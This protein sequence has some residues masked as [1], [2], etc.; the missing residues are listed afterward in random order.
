M[1][2]NCITPI[3]LSLLITF[4][5]P[6]S[7]SICQTKEK[8]KNLSI[9]EI[10]KLRDIE[11]QPEKVMDVI[12]LRQGMKIGEAGASYGYFTFKLSARVGN[13]GIVYANDIA[14]SALDK[15]ERKCKSD[16]ITNIKTV[17]GIED[18]PLFPNKNLDMIVVF[19]CLFEFSKPME[20]MLNSKKYLNSGGKLV[21]VDP[22]PS[23]EKNG[24][25]LTRKQI[26][27]YAEKAGYAVIM[28]D[29]SFL[30]RMMIIMLE[31]KILK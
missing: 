14:P 13:T 5:I 19:D 29:D 28:V 3:F 15:I 10:N 23:K 27:D 21:I 26:V 30:K 8:G 24:D 4:C 31:P 22:D 1:K 7:S 2:L 25:F 18:D 9:E 16:K 20:W 17:L 11:Q 6:F 12:K